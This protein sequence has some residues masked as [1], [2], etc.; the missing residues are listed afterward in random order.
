MIR[1][2]SHPPRA[3]ARGASIDPMPTP[4]PDAA[5]EVPSES[6]PDAPA[7]LPFDP[8]TAVFAALPSGP[9][10]ELAPGVSSDPNPDTAGSEPHP[11]TTVHP[12]GAPARTLL[13]PANLAVVFVGGTLGTAAREGLGLALPTAS[14]VPWAVLTA[15]LVGAFAL[16]LLLEALADRGGDHGIRRTLRLLLGTGFLGGFTTYSALAAGTAQLF[17]AGDGWLAASYALGTVVVG[18]GA[19]VAGILLAPRMRTEPAR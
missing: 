7:G 11:D 5:P 18:L 8:D 14:G 2:A 1:S 17:G 4:A 3:H 9:S 10:A 19:T 15:N 6:D 16:G 13:T 12:A